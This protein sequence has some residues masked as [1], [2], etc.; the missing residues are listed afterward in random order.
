MSSNTIDANE[1]A[2]AH[3]P[4]AAIQGTP[5]ER[6][7]GRGSMDVGKVEPLYEVRTPETEEYDDI[8][9]EEDLRTLRRVSGKIKWA[10]YTVAFAELAE[11]FSYYGSSILYTNFVQ[12]PL[13]EGSRTGAGGLHGQPGAL[14]MGQSASQG[15]SL[16]NSFFA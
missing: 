2:K 15:I 10:A 7:A 6:N 14:G 16:F 12:W 5:F 1:L 3:V 9:T 13:P 11:R 4:D 8:P